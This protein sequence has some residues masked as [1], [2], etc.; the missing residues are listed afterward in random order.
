MKVDKIIKWTIWIGI[1]VILICLLISEFAENESWWSIFTYV[2]TGLG[3]VA[4]LAIVAAVIR[5]ITSETLNIKGI[6]KIK[7]R[8]VH[9]NIQDLTNLVSREFFQGKN[10]HRTPV[11]D[12]FYDESSMQ[13]LSK[14][15]D[16]EKYKEDSESMLRLN[17]KNEIFAVKRGD[18]KT[19]D[20]LINAVKYI[21]FEGEAIDSKT[22]KEIYKKWYKID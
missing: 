3:Y 7:I 19:L 10:F 21:Y 8:R 14:D 9:S 20:A 1:S 15:P 18:I 16:L 6:G 17:V 5:F 12:A 22:L 11:L 2:E 4:N 13:V